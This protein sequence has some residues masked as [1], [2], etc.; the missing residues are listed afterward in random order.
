[1]IFIGIALLV[2]VGLAALVSSDA[3]ALL[4]LTQAQ[5][6]QLL[7]LLILLV[8]F[9][10]GAFGRRRRASELFGAMALWVAIFGVAALSYSYRDE[11]VGIAGRVAGELRPGVAVVD[12]DRGTATFRRGMGGHFEIAATV[13]GHTTP[14]IF[15]TGASAV[16]LTQ[17][18]AESA[19]IDTS[20]LRFSIPVSTANGTGQAARVRLDQI[21]VGGIVRQGVVAFVA[22]QNALETSLLGM[23]YLETLNRYSVSQNSLE[24]VD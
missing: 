24:L 5:T 22:E 18:D 4:G 16:V 15:D 2:A 13:N 7:P 20:K 11:L 9:A 6:A 23:T 1:M 17:A 8:V 19:G 10:G 3:G 21:E 12:S 14:M